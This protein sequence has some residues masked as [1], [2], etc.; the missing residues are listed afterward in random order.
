M[1]IRGNHHR[2]RRRLNNNSGSSNLVSLMRLLIT[3]NTLLLLLTS[4][5][6]TPAVTLS[7]FLRTGWL[8]ELPESTWR[9][10]FE[11]MRRGRAEGPGSPYYVSELALQTVACCDSPAGV[12]GCLGPKC[13]S[14]GLPPYS[15]FEPALDRLLEYLPMFD[16]VWVGTTY[17]YD[18]QW[19]NHTSM[20]AYA[21]LQA[22]V[23]RAFMDKYGNSDIS[24]GT[25]NTTITTTTTTTTT[26]TSSSSNLQAVVGGNNSSLSKTEK[27][28]KVN[29]AWYI[30]SEGGLVSTGLDPAERA[31]QQFFLR[32]S[33]TALHAVAPLP[34]L[35]SPSNGD[36]TLNA[37]ARAAQEQALGDLFCGLEHPLAL[38]FQDWL[39]QSVQF[40]F[41]FNYNYSNAFTCEADTVPTYNM[42]QR[43]VKRCPTRLT[44]AKVNVELFAERLNHGK[45]GED[46][47]ANIVNADPREIAQRLDCYRRHKL[48]IGACWAVPHWF[49]IWSYANQTVWHPY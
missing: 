27:K 1:G 24:S 39:G 36:I 30:T 29:W 33:M 43:I 37:T 49:G 31:T 18:T 23:G 11:L 3:T 16:R 40:T 19:G 42:L 25:T 45:K 7:L 15:L 2:R 6:P 28:K 4:C 13:S 21:Q 12:R 32:E 34:F 5:G 8:A 48:E 10:W 9:A 47:G 35:W 26:T 14:L 44:E 17:D 46:N 41:P 20:R 38:H 22:R